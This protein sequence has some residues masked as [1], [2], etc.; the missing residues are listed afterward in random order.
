MKIALVRG[1]F[2]RPSGILPWEDLHNTYDE[3]EV[4]AFVSDPPLH[5]TS[6]LQLPVESLPW[7]DGKTPLLGYDHFVFYA[8]RKFNFPRAILGGM[9]RLA[10]RFDVIHTS[11]NFNLFSAQAAKACA[12]RDTKFAFTAGENI[13]FYPDNIFTRWHKSYVNSSVDGATAT[14]IEGKRALIHEGVPHQKIN[15]VPNS[16]DTSDF[17][18]Q[19]VTAADVGLPPEFNNSFTILFVHRLCEQKGTPYLVQAFERFQEIAPDPTLILV[20]SREITEEKTNRR[21]EQNSS[22][23][24]IPKISHDS[25]SDYYN[26]SDLFVL[27]SVTMPSNEEQFGMS[28]IEAMACGT[29]SVV[30][31]VGGLPH[32]A[33]HGE[34]SLVVEERSSNDLLGAFETLFLDDQERK[35]LGRNSREYAEEN[36]EVDVVAEGL[37]DFY[38]DVLSITD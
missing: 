30:T 12:D 15:V 33:Q 36:Y 6:S 29:P 16:V 26:F 14:T 9:K 5:D 35:R 28:L 25:I 22:I 34:T 17:S 31:N 23:L 38:V 37:R 11:E 1:P 24:H 3:F 19:P 32:V 10:D 20:G 7:Y 21:I 2:L 8:L 13:S 27:P 4:T 18:P